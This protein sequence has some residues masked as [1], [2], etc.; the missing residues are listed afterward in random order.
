MVGQGTPMQRCISKTV[1]VIYWCSSRQ[2]LP[3]LI[4]F[5]VARALKK[6][7]ASCDNARTA[8]LKQK[9]ERQ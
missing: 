6:L 5:T 3:E 9:T 7:D 1:H 2:Q 8:K 4:N